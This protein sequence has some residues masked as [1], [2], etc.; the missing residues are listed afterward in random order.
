M[1]D[2]LQVTLNLVHAHP[3]RPFAIDNDLAE[4]LFSRLLSAVII[5]CEAGEVLD[6]RFRTEPGM[7][8]TNRFVLTLPKKLL[9]MDEDELFGSGP[10]ST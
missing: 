8:A 5:G 7:N 9:E 3:V 1:S 2:L 4:R 10:G 6:G